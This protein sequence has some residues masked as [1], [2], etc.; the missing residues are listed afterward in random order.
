[1]FMWNGLNMFR[2]VD[3]ETSYTTSYG[4]FVEEKNYMKSLCFVRLLFS[5]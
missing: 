4:R 3:D 1:M 2:E 5:W